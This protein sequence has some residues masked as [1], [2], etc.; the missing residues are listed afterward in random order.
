M[1]FNSSLIHLFKRQLT[2]LKEEAEDLVLKEKTLKKE[3]KRIE[4][5][6]ATRNLKNEHMMKAFI[7]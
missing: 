7:K 2:T 3:T 4:L 5:K 1:S 6:D